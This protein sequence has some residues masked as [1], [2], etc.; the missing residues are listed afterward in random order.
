VTW[1]GIELK[2]P[3]WEDPNAQI[4]AYTLAA[5][6]ENEEDLHIILNMSEDTVE[7]LLPQ[8]PGR[9]WHLAI[10]TACVSPGDIVAPLQQNQVRAHTYKI[11]PRS[12]IVLESR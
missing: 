6:D 1:H 3:L 4:L 8:L 12:V 5:V 2:A 10:D 9:G 11:A 7:I